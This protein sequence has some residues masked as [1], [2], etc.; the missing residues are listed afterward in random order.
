[1][2][3]NH[4]LNKAIEILAQS[5]NIQKFDLQQKKMQKIFWIIISSIINN[6]IYIIGCISAISMLENDSASALI[7]LF[8]YNQIFKGLTQKQQGYLKIQ[9]LNGL[10]YYNRRVGQLEKALKQLECALKVIKKYSLQE[11]AVTHLNLSKCKESSYTKSQRILILYQKSCINVNIQ[12]SMLCKFFNNLLLQCWSLGKQFL[13]TLICILSICIKVSEDNLGIHSCLTNQLKIIYEEFARL[14]VIVET[15]FT[16]KI[17]NLTK[18]YQLIYLKS[19]I[20]KITE[21][22][23]QLE[24]NRSGYLIRPKSK[25]AIMRQTQS[26]KLKSFEFNIKKQMSTTT[27]F[28]QIK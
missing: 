4:Q 28:K 20:K 3:N 9:I 1:M 8:G 23:I 17:L 24:T 26:L 10:G 16:L 2:I 18:C 15:T 27:Q 12:V 14:I 13:K 19:I 7:L 5:M 22:L 6:E 25:L 11:V 21:R